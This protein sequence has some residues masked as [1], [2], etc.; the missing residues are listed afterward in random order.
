VNL[1]GAFQARV[2]AIRKQRRSL[3]PTGPSAG[4]TFKDPSGDFAGRLIEAAGLKGRRV[5]DVAVSEKHAN[6][7]L[8]L[9]GAQ[10]RDVLAL[11]AVVQREV[12][13]RF[14]VSLEP[15]VKI[16]GEP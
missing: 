12:R 8:N 9:G 5:G 6:F 15:E 10:A 16:V 13:A 14:G 7:L 2:T 4:S 3:Q 1:I 11:I